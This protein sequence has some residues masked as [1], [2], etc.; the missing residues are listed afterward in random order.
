M[1][2]GDIGRGN[3]VSLCVCEQV[4]SVVVIYK[5]KKSIDKII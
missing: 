1:H 3:D 4:P 5:D 2:G